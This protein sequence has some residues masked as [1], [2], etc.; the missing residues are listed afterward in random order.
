MKIIFYVCHFMPRI[1]ARPE[2]EV[3]ANGNLLRDSP[4][5]GYILLI[6]VRSPGDQLHVVAIKP[7]D[8]DKP[9]RE[10]PPDSSC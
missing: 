2:L 5:S 1:L 3:P 7:G 4:S 8:A 9:C 6:G 10:M